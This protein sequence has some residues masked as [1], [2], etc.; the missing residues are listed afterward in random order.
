LKDENADLLADFHRIL[1]RWKSYFSR[2][3]NAVCGVSDVRQL[4]THATVPVARD[5]TAFEIDRACSID[6][7]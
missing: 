2:L 5:P 4:G 3:L 7:E 6:G 1:S